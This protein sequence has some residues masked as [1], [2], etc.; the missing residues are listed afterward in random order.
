M[1]TTP[2]NSQTS[3]STESRRSVKDI[4][5]HDSADA[6]PVSQFKFSQKP[7]TE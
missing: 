1:M 5:A 2:L 4:Q 7:I 3:L 6:W